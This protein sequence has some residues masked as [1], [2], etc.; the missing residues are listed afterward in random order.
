M[1]ENMQ[2]NIWVNKYP[3]GKLYAADCIYTLTELH[4]VFNI[5]SAFIKFLQ[6]IL[7]FRIQLSDELL[8]TAYTM[9]NCNGLTAYIMYWY[10]GMELNHQPLPYQSSI[11]TVEL[12]EHIE[13]Q[14]CPYLF[15]N[16][17]GT[18]SASL[19]SDR[20]ASTH[21]ETQEAFCTAI[22]MRLNRHTRYCA[23]FACK[24]QAI[25]CTLGLLGLQSSKDEQ[26]P[27]IPRVRQIAQSEDWVSVSA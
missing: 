14:P 15:S 11:L 13:R 27:I 22:Y 20:A 2:A 10:S 6:Y 1:N 9:Q 25:W 12:P 16:R 8:T 3:M 18:G 21:A 19:C 4:I 17:E 24:T 7:T 5:H 23:V 26:E